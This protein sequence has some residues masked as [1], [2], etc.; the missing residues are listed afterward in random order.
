MSEKKE[1]EKEITTKLIL[2]SPQPD[3]SYLQT[4]ISEYE[5]IRTSCL[6]INSYVIMNNGYVKKITDVEEGDRLLGGDGTPMNILSVKR[7]S[8]T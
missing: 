6:G 7:K 8:K 3:G 5:K 2:I 1:N 4:D